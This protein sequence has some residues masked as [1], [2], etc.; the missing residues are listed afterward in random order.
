MNRLI[1]ILLLILCL[2]LHSK[3]SIFAVGEID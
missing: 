2:C 3:I 1:A